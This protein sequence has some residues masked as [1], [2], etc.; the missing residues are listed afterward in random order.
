MLSRSDRQVSCFVISSL[1]WW[2]L[3]G[4]GRT[5]NITHGIEEVGEVRWELVGTLALAWIICYF[6]IWKGVKY[7]GKVR[8]PCSVVP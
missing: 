4:R 1:I 5:L 2:R 8:M 7:T 6:C 3:C